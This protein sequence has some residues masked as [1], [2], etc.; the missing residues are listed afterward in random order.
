MGAIFGGRMTCGHRRGL[1]LALGAEKGV[2]IP[3]RAGV[4][5]GNGRERPVPLALILEAAAIDG[6]DDVGVA[7]PRPD[8]PDSR[9]DLGGGSGDR[10][11]ACARS[12]SRWPTK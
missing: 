3:V 8:E 11:G 1:A 4:L 2:A 10:A 6:G 9:L 7:A 5:G 12:M